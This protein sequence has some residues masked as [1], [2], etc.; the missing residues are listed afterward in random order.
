M[1]NVEK[2]NSLK[3]LNISNN[4]ISNF[5]Q[6]LVKKLNSGLKVYYDGNPLFCDC[7]IR[8]LY[9]YLLT[10]PSEQ[11]HFANV[12]CDAPAFVHGKSLVDVDDNHLN[13]NSEVITLDNLK[14]LPDIRFR[15]IA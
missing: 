8:P 3:V 12:H 1:K 2:L 5:D 14:L 6:I 10:K 7:H 4:M 13:C 11:S 15:E 9:H